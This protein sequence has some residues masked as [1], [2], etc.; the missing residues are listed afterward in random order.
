M[1][2]V[3]PRIAVN[4]VGITQAQI[5][6][7]VQYHP[8]PN[9][10][11]AQEEAARA[12]VVK[13]LL[14]QRAAKAGV[15]KTCGCSP[16]EVIES[17]LKQEVKTPLPDEESC[18]RYYEANRKKF[19]TTPLYEA[20]HILFLAPPDDDKARQDALCRAKEVLERLKEAPDS[21]PELARVH[22]ACT[23]AKDGGHLGQIGKDQTLPA[24]EAALRGMAEGEISREPVATE[25]G[26]HLIR[27]HHRAEGKEM[28]FEAVRGWIEKHLKTQS[29]QNA[30]R[31]YVQLLAGE[32]DIRGYA[33]PTAA[34]TPLVQ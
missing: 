5:D 26:F 8:A 31:Q 15:C 17:L 1:T 18:R 13:E 33:F 20:S 3:K 12:L 10:F 27:L 7:E 11:T 2:E 16:E 28:P 6:A 9:F 34:K 25:V 19:M 24:F 22:S 23:T 21:F 14:L 4:G 32:A 30:V 29:W